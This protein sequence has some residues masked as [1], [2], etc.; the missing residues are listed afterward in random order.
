MVI[1]RDTSSPKEPNLIQEDGLE[2]VDVTLRYRPLSR[3]RRTVEHTTRIRFEELVDPD[4][5]VD[6]IISETCQTNRYLAL[7]RNKGFYKDK[8]D[9][10]LTQIIYT[11]GSI[12]IIITR[13]IPSKIPSFLQKM[14]ATLSKPKEPYTVRYH[15]NRRV[16][17]TQIPA[18][19]GHTIEG[20]PAKTIEEPLTASAEML[21]TYVRQFTGRVIAREVFVKFNK[22]ELI[23][24]QSEY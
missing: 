14:R 19:N 9:I 10:N 15:N 20:I 18:P 12:T 6:Q 8:G 24:D 17:I 7:T 3:G 5:V 11:D 23:A 13:K 16:S 4:R 22:E 1:E 2:Q 21:H